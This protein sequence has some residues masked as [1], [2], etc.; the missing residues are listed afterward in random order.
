M[1]PAQP[2]WEHQTTHMGL[3][4]CADVP[5]IEQ[6]WSESLLNK[7]LMSFSIIP[8]GELD[9]DISVISLSLGLEY[10]AFPGLLGD[11]AK[12]NNFL[13]SCMSKCAGTHVE[14]GLTTFRFL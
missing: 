2:F 11:I 9:H 10:I 3:G 5:N 7:D 14:L 8:M 4:C 12:L 6:F 1:I 13:S